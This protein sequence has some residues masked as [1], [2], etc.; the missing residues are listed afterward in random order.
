M[1]E[2]SEVSDVANMSEQ[3]IAASPG[4][5]LIYREFA[6]TCHMEAIKRHRMD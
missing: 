1:V 6:Q 3:A 4:M 5:A 2:Q